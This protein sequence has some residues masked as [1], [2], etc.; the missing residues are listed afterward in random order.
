LTDHSTASGSIVPRGARARWLAYWPKSSNADVTDGGD[1]GRPPDAA[2]SPRSGRHLAILL[3]LGAIFGK[4]L[5]FVREI[6]M[7]HVFGASM[8]ADAFRAAGTGTMLPLALFQNESVPAILIPTH[9]SWQEE[10]GAPRRFAALT[11]ALTA[12]GVAI[13]AFIQVFGA[14][15]VSALVGGFSPEGQAITLDFLQIM[16]L[17]MPASVM[18]NVLASGEIALGRSRLTTIRASLLNVSVIAGLVIIFLTHW[19]NALAWSFAVA[20]NGLGA[21]GLWT[22]VRDGSLSFRGL[23][24]GEVLA[25]AADF[26]RK[27]LPFLFVPLADQG[28]IW[29]ERVL[30]S[31]TAVGSVAS[32]DYARTITD[33]AVLFISQPL[34]LALLSKT[35]TE[36]EGAR[37]Q[38]VIRR[39]LVVSAPACVCLAIFAPDVARIVFARG[40]FKEAAVQMT[41]ETLRGISVGLWASTIGW[42]VLRMLNRAGR[43]KTAAMIL[44][45]AY[46]SNLLFNVLLFQFPIADSHG[47]LVLGLG[48]SM[49]GLVLLGATV[50]CLGLTRS[51]IVSLL[52]AAIPALIMTALGLSIEGIFTGSLVRLLLAGIACSACILAACAL[53]MPE[54]LNVGVR[55]C[56]RIFARMSGRA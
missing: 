18:L 1:A 55:Q 51:M 52:L 49:R 10:G 26:F 34:G 31:R 38:A 33:S 23:T 4:A 21:W 37:I 50:V 14:A 3:M 48:E 7:A 30:A 8:V 17:G 11:V 5:G 53:L 45:S 25:A 16:A 29:M 54:M 2:P 40:A 47:T 56:M 12:I 41:G 13:M 32:L 42:V 24:M 15:W 9:K 20:F 22:L 35:A 43:N 46:L 44:V 27:L 36:D 6:L 28:N 19:V 39:L